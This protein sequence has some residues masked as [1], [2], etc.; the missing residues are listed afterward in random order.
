MTAGV[1]SELKLLRSSL[2]S[3]W[4][5]HVEHCGVVL[6]DYTT[7]EIRNIATEDRE[8]AIAG[9]DLCDALVMHGKDL[10]NVIGIFHTHPS[11][12]P[13]PS[14]GDMQGWPVGKLRYFIVTQSDVYEWKR[15][16]HGTATRCTIR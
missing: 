8:F 6:D 2:V 4:D 7:M 3:Y 1:R 16:P 11:N 9:E 10:E 14:C 5:E 13:H 15:T 12:R